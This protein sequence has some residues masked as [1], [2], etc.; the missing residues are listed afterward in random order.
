ML[1]CIKAHTVDTFGTIPVGSL[2]DADSPYVVEA[3]NFVDAD[4]PADVDDEEN[5]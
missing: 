5:D 4:A 2:W 1:R 3:A